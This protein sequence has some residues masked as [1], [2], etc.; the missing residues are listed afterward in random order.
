MERR[1]F[2]RL[3]LAATPLAARCARTTPNQPASA[4]APIVIIGAG[5]AGL[6][7]ADILRRAGRQIVVLEARAFAGGRVQTIHAPF[8]EQLHGEAGPIRI[9]SLHQ[10]VIRLA[11]EHGLNLIPFSS[12]NGS[13]LIRIGGV[14]ARANPPDRPRFSLA[15]RGNERGLTQGDL[16][17]HYIGRLPEDL[18]SVEATSASYRRWAEYDRVSWP[19]WLRSRGASPDAVKLMTVGGDSSELS[20]LYVLRQYALLR[21][22]RGQSYKIEGGM[23]RLPR[24]MAAKLGS[25]VRYNAAVTGLERTESGVAVHHLETGEQKTVAASHV[26]VTIPFSTLRHV[27]VRPPFSVK[28]QQ[29]IEQL[30]YFPAT[31]FL[32]QTR[33]RFWAR[34]GLS[35][36]AR[37]DRPAEIWDSAYDQAADAGLLGATVGGALGRDLLDRSE[38]QTMRIGEDV[39]AEPFADAS[40]EIQKTA[41]RRWALEP[42]SKGAFAVA[43]PGQMSSLMPDLAAPEGRVYFAGEHTSPWMGWMEGAL[44]SAERVVREVLR[45]A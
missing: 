33:S 22:G 3:A 40:G 36:Y 25:L 16:L 15:L 42:W 29:A 44:E 12:S 20:A 37:T 45:G 43:H 1:H 18:A 13:E 2:L 4:S 5:L 35:G 31:R 32:V 11:R 8:D 24:A 17:E 9:S 14:N 30:P 23:D 26:I 27:D 7:A 10:I 6:H 34:S 19:E 21:E 38:E 39:I 28:K 41:A